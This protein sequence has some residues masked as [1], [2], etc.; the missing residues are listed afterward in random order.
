MLLNFKSSRSF[1]DLTR[2][3]VFPWVL[4]GEASDFDDTL[5]SILNPNNYRDLS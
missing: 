4:K 2:Y 1:I 3:P 5:E